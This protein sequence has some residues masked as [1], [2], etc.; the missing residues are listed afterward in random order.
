MRGK[1]SSLRVRFQLARQRLK[2][3]TTWT[4]AAAAGLILTLGGFIFY[5]TNVLNDYITAT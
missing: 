3:A 2:G 1:E 4:A 5:N